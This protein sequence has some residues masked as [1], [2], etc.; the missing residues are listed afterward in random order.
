MR[1][2][3]TNISFDFMESVD[4]CPFA[5]N[6]NVFVGPPASQNA[7]NGSFLPSQ[8]LINQL[9]P[10]VKLSPKYGG[11]MLWNRYYDIT[12][13]QYSSRIRGSV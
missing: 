9:L 11:V 2:W 10:F 3:I 12:I 6:Q 5:K 8:V 13:N 7:S 1:T 4:Q